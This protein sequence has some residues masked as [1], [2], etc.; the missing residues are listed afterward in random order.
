MAKS[1]SG[2]GSMAELQERSK[3]DYPGGE[4]NS[5]TGLTKG[6]SSGGVNSSSGLEKFHARP[7]SLNGSG[8]SANINKGDGLSK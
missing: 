3:A 8:V 2:S 6:S 4:H 5:G 1:K 7:A